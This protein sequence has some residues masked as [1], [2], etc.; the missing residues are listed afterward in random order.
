MSTHASV[1]VNIRLKVKKDYIEGMTSTL[2]LVPIGAWHGN[3]RKHEW[4]SPILLAV[5][6]KQTDEYES[7]CRCMSG[8]TDEFY[9]K[10]KDF[11]A[12]KQCSR[13]PYY[14][15]GESCAVW[16]EPVQVWCVQG[17]DFT[18]SPVHKGAV[19]ILDPSRGIGVR[20][21][22]FLH[23][24]EDKQPEDATDSVELAQH[25]RNQPSVQALRQELDLVDSTA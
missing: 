3:G 21:P 16:F 2:D 24:R 22:R 13:K 8:F 19:G 11:Y 20:F 18:L 15:T 1:H 12:D 6:N 10:M 17:A 7:V 23:V 5:Y 14:V 9:K 4:W 25:Y